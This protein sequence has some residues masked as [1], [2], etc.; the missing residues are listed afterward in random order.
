MKKILNEH[1][2]LNVGIIFLFIGLILNF[3]SL[4]GSFGLPQINEKFF[5]GIN[6]LSITSILFALFFIVGFLRFRTR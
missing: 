6:S 5:I 3:W 2:Y 4:L 1:I